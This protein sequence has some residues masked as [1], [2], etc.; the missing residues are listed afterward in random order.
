VAEKQLAAALVRTGASSS[1]DAVSVQAA[2]EREAADREAE[3]VRL[4]NEIAS[5]R[6]EATKVCIQCICSV[7]SYT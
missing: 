7:L 6:D 5:A 1:G 4:Q 3:L 2:L